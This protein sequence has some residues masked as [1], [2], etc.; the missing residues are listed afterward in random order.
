MSYKALLAS[1]LLITVLLLFCVEWGLAQDNVNDEEALSNND[2]PHSIGTDPL[3]PF[4]NSFALI[5]AY[6]L[7]KPFGLVIGVWYSYATTTPSVYL[8]YPGAV[9]TIAM[10]AGFRWFIWRGLHLEYQLLPGYNRFYEEDEHKYYHS[11]GIYNEFRFGYRFDFKVYDI[12]FFVNIQWP[13]GFSLY[14]SNEP[15][16]FAEVNRQDPI[17]YIFFPNIYLGFRF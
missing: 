2:Y 3:L 6:D 1:V 8:E 12:P 14:E 5:Y 13:I 10:V 9:Q 4:F 15:A 17:F 16:S 7:H 11:F